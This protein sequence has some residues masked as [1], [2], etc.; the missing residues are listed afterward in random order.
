LTE[1]IVN[2]KNKGTMTKG[3]ISDRDRLAKRVKAKA[4]KG[5]DTEQNAQYRLATYITLKNRKEGSSKK[6]KRYSKGNNK[7]KSN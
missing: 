4:I 2:I 1:E 7:S 3:E 6:T 5:K